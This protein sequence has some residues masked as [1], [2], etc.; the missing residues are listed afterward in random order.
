MQMY[1]LFSLT[2]YKGD[3]HRIYVSGDGERA[4]KLPCEILTNNLRIGLD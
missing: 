2:E 3:C 4:D 1:L